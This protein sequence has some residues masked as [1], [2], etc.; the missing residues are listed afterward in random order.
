MS[1][2]ASTKFWNRSNHVFPLIANFRRDKSAKTDD[3]FLNKF[4]SK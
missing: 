1:H 3:E 4:L 2:K